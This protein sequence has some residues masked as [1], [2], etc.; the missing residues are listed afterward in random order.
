[1]LIR[2]YVLSYMLYSHAYPLHNCLLNGIKLNKSTEPINTTS[3]LI[4][5]HMKSIDIENCMSKRFIFL[6]KRNFKFIL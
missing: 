1:M 4:L 6:L 2:N 3:I 5:Y